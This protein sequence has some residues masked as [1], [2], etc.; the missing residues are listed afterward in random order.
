MRIGNRIHVPDRN[1]DPDREIIQR[2][3]DLYR[4]GKGVKRTAGRRDG[5]TAAAC[6]L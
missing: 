1:V 6:G 2:G 3:S 5:R 4:E